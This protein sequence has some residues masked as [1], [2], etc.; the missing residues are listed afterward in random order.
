[1]PPLVSSYRVRKCEMD[2]NYHPDFLRAVEKF[3]VR[4]P[5]QTVFAENGGS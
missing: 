3:P 1:M 5:L 4:N 2:V